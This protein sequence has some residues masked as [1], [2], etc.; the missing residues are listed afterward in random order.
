MKL[1]VSDYDRTFKSNIK[2]L[3]INVL[4]I[5]DFRA[6]GN[7][8]VL[9]TGR[10]YESIKNETNIYE[11]EYDYLICNNGH[12]IFDN[13][14]N[15]ISS[16]ILSKEE[17]LFIFKLLNMNYNV[18]STKVF[19]LYSATSNYDNVL[20]VYANFD[21]S[22]NSKKFKK[23][24]ESINP[25]IYCYRVDDSLYIGKRVN[26]AT[27]ISQIREIEKIPNDDI[28]TVG[29]GSNDY[30]ML[31]EYKGYKMFK[32]DKAL[33]NKEIPTITQVHRLVKKLM[34]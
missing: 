22:E 27:A 30:E 1:L 2:N 14:N 15:I 21:S 16:N 11:I 34:K 25:S 18:C 3:C 17:I 29:D 5:D 20:E 8:F 23:Y 24:I 32:S 26:K 10:T 33:W 19:G 31:K 28:Y 12:I 13:E 6:E 9:A 7:K 4:Y